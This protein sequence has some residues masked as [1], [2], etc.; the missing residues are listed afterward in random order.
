V[1]LSLQQPRTNLHIR[2]DPVLRVASLR[3]SSREQNKNEEPP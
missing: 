1:N 3:T 2:N